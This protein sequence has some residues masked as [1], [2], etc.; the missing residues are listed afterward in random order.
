[1]R[2]VPH[3]WLPPLVLVQT[4]PSS[5]LLRSQSCCGQR[6]RWMAPLLCRSLPRVGVH[7]ALPQA[8][9]RVEWY[10]KGPHECYPDR[11]TGAWLRRHAAADASELHVPYIFPGTVPWLRCRLGSLATP[12]SEA[13]E[14]C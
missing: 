10:G 8:M 4:C 2:A 3:C 13:P 11:K 5:V 7:L 14:L 6:S 1:M 12:P 9:S